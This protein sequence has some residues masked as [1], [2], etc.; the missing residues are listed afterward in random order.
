MRG[1]RKTAAS[2]LAAVIVVAA[3]AACGGRVSGEQAGGAAGNEAA[4][5]AQAGGAGVCDLSTARPR[6]GASCAGGSVTFQLAAPSGSR[7]WLDESQSSGTPDRNWLTLLT[8][9][10]VEVDRAP[11]AES[12]NRDCASCPSSWSLTTGTDVWPLPATDQS[13][14]WD[15]TLYAP[16]TCGPQSLACV[17]PRCAAPGRYVAQMCACDAADQ[18]PLGCA[19]PTCV[20]VPFEYPSDGLVVGL[21]PSSP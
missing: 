14:T 7:W 18:G 12:T 15:G 6:I 8:A 19:R 5:S 2:A 13:E 3:L 20:S 21:L 9:C 11:N 16:G 10:G 4:S 1:L 17:A